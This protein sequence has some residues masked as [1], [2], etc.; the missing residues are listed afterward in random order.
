MSA[1]NAEKVRSMRLLRNLPSIS[2]LWI[3]LSEVRAETWA[4]GARHHGRVIEGAREEAAQ[5]NV[6]FRRA[7]L[8]KAVIW[9]HSRSAAGMAEWKGLDHDRR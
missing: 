1:G 8:L 5:R 2:S 7:I 9:Q 4:L 3:P 6:S